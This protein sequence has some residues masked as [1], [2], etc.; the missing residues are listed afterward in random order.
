VGAYK[1]PR[2]AAE[3]FAKLK[4]AGLNP[5]YEQF[6]EYYRVVLAGLRQEELK[7]VAERLGTAGF[8]EVLLREER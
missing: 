2:Y 8:R 5:A 7:A 3:T 4:T 6:G 1:Q